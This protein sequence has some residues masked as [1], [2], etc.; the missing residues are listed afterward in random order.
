[1]THPT[2]LHCARLL[3]QPGAESVQHSAHVTEANIIPKWCVSCKHAMQVMD[4]H[5]NIL[6][7][8][9]LETKFVK[10]GACA[11]CTIGM[12]TGMVAMQLV[13]C[14]IVAA[15]M[16]AQQQQTGQQQQTAMSEMVALGQSTHVVQVGFADAS[17]QL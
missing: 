3:H 16:V 7:K 15:D 14:L 10:V 6:C 9:H 17:G 13:T 8:Q 1:M 12:C 11:N 5:M 4:K 2:A